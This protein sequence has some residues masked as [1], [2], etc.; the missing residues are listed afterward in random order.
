M[1]ENKT[2]LDPATT[3]TVAYQGITL[4]THKG[5]PMPYGATP[6]RNGV[7]FAIFSRH[8]A[9]VTLCFFPGDGQE[10][11]LCLNPETNR[12]G[13]VWHI[14]VDQFPRKWTYGWRV[15]GPY[16]PQVNGHRFNPNKLLIDP[17]AKALVGS[18]IWD[19]PALL[20]YK[21]SQSD[22]TYSTEDSAPFVPKCAVVED[23]FDWENDHPPR[24]PMK[25]AIIY[26]VHLKG[27]T[28]D[29]SS[30]VKHPGT[31]KGF[32]E[33]IPYLKD[34]GIT[35]VEL[36]P[37]FSFD[38]NENVRI[39]PETGEPLT[40]YWGYSTN[41]FFAPKASY[42]WGKNYE[43][44]IR[45]FKEMVK[46]LHQN[47]MEVIL[48]VV[49][50]HTAEGDQMGPTFSFRGLD[51]S[52]F[53]ML[54]DDKRYFRNYS[55]CGNTF[56]CNHPFVR[57]FVLE[58]LRYW[59]VEMH[60]DGF[61]FDLA[62]ILGRAQDGSV[63]SNPPLL[64]HIA[65]DPILADCKIIA[66]A[67]DAAGLYQVGSFPSEG[68]WAEWNGLYRDDIRRFV[69][70]DH[71][72]MSLA[73]TRLTGSSDLYKH[74]GRSPYHSINFITSHDGFTLSDL[75]CYN[76]KH[77][78]ANGEGNRDGCN[79][80]LSWNC[81]IEG[82]TR[83]TAVRMLRTRQIKNFWTILMISQGVP[84]ILGG[85]EFSRTQNGNNNAYCQ[86]NA[87]SWLDWTLLRKHETMYRFAREMIHFRKRQPTLR[88]YS[89]LVGK[90]D[91]SSPI[92][93]ITW[94]DE[95]LK[96]PNWQAKRPYLA[97][98]LSGEPAHTLSA[99]DA[100]DVF[101]VLNMSHKAVPT[102]LP[103]PREDRQ[104]HRAVDTSLY[105]PNDIASEGQ[106]TKLP[107]QTIYTVPERTCLVLTGK[108][109]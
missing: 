32:M 64:E 8:A 23:D 29:P 100:D 21:I 93:D 17:Y 52:L 55:G 57:N 7:N 87:I 108:L 33:K 39:N 45:E 47:N 107:N 24:I 68:R 3:G 104:W 58:S 88:R 22:L 101:V 38:E 40:N 31:F 70:G 99:E 97:F 105:P 14:F 37:V 90:P 2:C 60:V 103:V 12:T 20:G 43:A 73:A 27:F 18:F 35:A 82:P 50:N 84:M 86:D 67:W 65:H 53:Y 6:T 75:V 92:R 59:V 95:N 42:A 16:C 94:F 28:R 74:D 19:S 69:K 30:Q 106:E 71:G 48:D 66:E 80:N 25:D 11:R 36:L 89:F 77:N 81:G 44:A 98:M 91:G 61:R 46:A 1:L 15:N 54:S 10:L 51:N 56:N 79:H 62:S 85:D 49:Y 9:E 78:N 41:A 4:T 13:N 5:K 34:L 63:L 102:H 26:E 76:D 96:Q 109:V 83:D 72:T